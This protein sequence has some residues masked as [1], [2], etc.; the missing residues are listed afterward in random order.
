MK[1]E[2]INKFESVLFK[3]N[4]SEINRVFSSE[5]FFK[6]DLTNSE[7]WEE[8]LEYLFLNLK[9]KNF[10]KEKLKKGINL[11]IADTKEN[12]RNYIIT[13]YKE[14]ECLEIA[15]INS[16]QTILTKIFIRTKNNSRKY[17]TN[18]WYL[19]SQRTLNEI[20]KKEHKKLQSAFNSKIINKVILLKDYLLNKVRDIK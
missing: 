9:T 7:F 3:N 20:S 14:G 1:L 13:E 6:I 2:Q 16:N 17:P 18:I 19:E 10:K 4:I 8:F 11:N 15:N 12:I 5:V